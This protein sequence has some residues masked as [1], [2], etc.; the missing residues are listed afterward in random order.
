MK[1]I[2]KIAALFLFLLVVLP[3]AVTLFTTYRFSES[4]CGK[5]ITLAQDDEKVRYLEKWADAA[6]R[7]PPLLDYLGKPDGRN[8]AADA[9][10]FDRIDIDWAHL[11]LGRDA[12]S[13]TL[14]PPPVADTPPAGPVTAIGIGSGRDFIAVGVNGTTDMT[15]GRG[16]KLPGDYA[17]MFT[18]AGKRTVVYCLTDTR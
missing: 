15:L 11:A 10:F 6:I 3:L 14:L 8:A 13:V 4:D 1:T 5:L 2:L 7:Q 18:A 9:D 16:G 12:A 17:E